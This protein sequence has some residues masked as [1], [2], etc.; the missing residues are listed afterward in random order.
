MSPVDIGSTLYTVVLSVKHAFLLS[1]PLVNA[2]ESLH[3]ALRQPT[4][5][6]NWTVNWPC[7]VSAS[8]HRNEIAT[9]LDR[10]ILQNAD[11]G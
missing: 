5:D 10:I 11:T 7:M 6:T 8:V 1:L 2:R 4:I 3:T 9:A